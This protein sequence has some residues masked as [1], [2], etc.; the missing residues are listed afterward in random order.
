MA[1]GKFRS[2]EGTLVSSRGAWAGR[3]L[4]TVTVHALPGHL[5]S[6]LLG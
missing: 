5:P 3:G 2:Q 6:G 4:F 1:P